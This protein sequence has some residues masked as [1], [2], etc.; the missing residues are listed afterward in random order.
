MIQFTDTELNSISAKV[1]DAIDSLHEVAYANQE[2]VDLVALGCAMGI[3]IAHLKHI[4][5]V[6]AKKCVELKQKDPLADEK[7]N[8]LQEP[9]E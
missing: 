5:T 1:T 9:W 4:E 3:A 8:F 6:I 2:P 7:Y